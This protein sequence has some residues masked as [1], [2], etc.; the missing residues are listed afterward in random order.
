MTTRVRDA[1]LFL[2]L[3]FLVGW[4]PCRLGWAAING[5]LVGI[6]IL[7]GVI[8]G[9]NGIAILTELPILGKVVRV[10]LSYAAML[11]LAGILIGPMIWMLL[12]SLRLPKSPIPPLNETLPMVT[13]TVRT[14]GVQHSVVRPDLHWENY[15]TVLNSP[16]LPVR[17]FFA[18]TV[19]VTCTVVFFQLLFSSLCAFGLSRMRFRGRG[20]V[21]ALFIGSMMFAGPVTQIPVYL[22]MRAFGW[23]DTYWALIVPG[24]SSAFSV[25]LLR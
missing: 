15:D 2:V 21:F 19:F 11:G 1:I 3:A 4:I 16:S 17:R 23:L 18:N 13:A 9:L 22:M 25:F 8:L 5:W 24:V 6:P 20:I 12:V 14:N 10:V 7:I